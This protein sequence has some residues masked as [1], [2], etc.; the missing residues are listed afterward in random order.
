[1]DTQKTCYLF[2][3]LDGTVIGHDG[4][5]S[6]ANL[7]AM[8]AVQR[9]GHKL[10]L[11]TGRSN[12]AYQ[13]SSADEARVIPWNGTCF[14]TA[15]VT[16]EGRQITS[17]T[18]SKK[19]FDVWLEYCM[20]HRR[21][22]FCGGRR[23]TATFIF[24]T[25]TEPLTEAEKQAWRARA[26]KSFSEDAFTNLTVVGVL[27]PNTLPESDLTVVQ[28]ATY[29]D[30]FPKGC[31]KG[32]VILDFCQTLGVSIDQCACFGDSNNDLDMFRVCSTSVCMKEA[33]PALA[34][35][36][37]YRAKTEEGVAEGLRYLFGI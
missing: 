20:E 19:D 31:N 1:M 30:L 24:R 17:H 11:N 3:D 10:I 22:L 35:L 21:T 13:M 15:D 27:D 34:E 2:F 14:S 6:D 23:A 4:T 7:Q 33:T 28:L 36:A 9:L 37:T 12:G 8:L 25:Y 32:Q 16:F 26:S 18:V 29:A 5:L